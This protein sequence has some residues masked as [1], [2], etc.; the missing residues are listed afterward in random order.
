VAEQGVVL[1][2]L[3]IILG[4]PAG[5][6]SGHRPITARAAGR[7]RLATCS[8]EQMYVGRSRLGVGVTHQLAQHE[9]VDTCGCQLCPVGV[10]ETVRALPLSP[11][12]FCGG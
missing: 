8:F 3:V 5:H 6:G 2:E 9:Q 10:P 4:G 12:R 7:T 1:D 11:P